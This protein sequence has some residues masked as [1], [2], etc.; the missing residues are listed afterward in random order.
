MSKEFEVVKIDDCSIGDVCW[1]VTRHF[2]KP[3]YGEI[4]AI[5][6]TENAIQIMTD[7][8][9]FRLALCD[10]CFWNEKDAKEFRK[11]LKK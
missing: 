4:T 1:M 11:N 6:K 7:H 5:F 3:L 2:I 8:D 9:G 10:H